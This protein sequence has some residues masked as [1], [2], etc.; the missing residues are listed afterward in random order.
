MHLIIFSRTKVQH[1]FSIPMLAD[2]IKDKIDKS[3]YEWNFLYKGQ[4]ITTKMNEWREW[5]NEWAISYLN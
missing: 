4:Y 5:M 2:H 1:E 3:C